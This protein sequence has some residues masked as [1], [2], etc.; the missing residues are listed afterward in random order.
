MLLGLN[1]GYVEVI[2]GL[3]WGNGKENG[4]YYLG[5]RGLR[6]LRGLGFR[7]VEFGVYGLGVRV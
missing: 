4:N 7:G 1:W 6:G 2:V 5:L 3:Y